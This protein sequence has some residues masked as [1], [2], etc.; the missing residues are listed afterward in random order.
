MTPELFARP[1]LP[2]RVLF[3][4]M[5]GLNGGV[6]FDRIRKAVLNRKCRS[7]YSGRMKDRIA[8]EWKRAVPS[9]TIKCSSFISVPA[10]PL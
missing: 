10:C 8:D 3:G 7:E 5:S 6:L 4:E 1:L 2:R 9:I